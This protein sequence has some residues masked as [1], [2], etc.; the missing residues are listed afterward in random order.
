[1]LEQFPVD[2]NNF[3]GPVL[4]TGAGGCIGS[5]VLALL[6]R[7][8][9]PVVAFDLSSDKR[10]PSLLLDES[11]L[12]NITWI[13]G[14]IART[15]DVSKAVE[16]SGANAI[17]HLAALQVPF[18]AADPVDGARVNVVGTTNV[19]E[20]ARH[21]NLKRLAYASSVAAH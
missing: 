11:T 15:E 6:S 12:S 18:C 16:N 3:D 9:V 5:W 8:R 1:M 13:K 21:N 4:V 2:A 14:D 10:R 19:F 17:I 7:A 20:A